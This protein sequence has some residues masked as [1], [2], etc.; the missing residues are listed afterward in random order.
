MVH[1]LA[2]KCRS[3]ERR[4]L[5]TPPAS[6]RATPNNRLTTRPSLLNGARPLRLAAAVALLTDGHKS[7]DFCF[8][9]RLAYG[10]R[11]ST[12]SQAAPAKRKQSNKERILF[13]FCNFFFTSDGLRLRPYIRRRSC[14][15]RRGGVG[16]VVQAAG[17]GIRPS[18][19]RGEGEKE[20]GGLRRSD[21]TMDSKRPFAPPCFVVVVV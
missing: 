9:P 21:S 10:L 13:R 20:E 3:G 18:K 7:Y 15:A 19:Q 5:L 6:Q 14:K 8:H 16:G 12:S 11:R 4:T 2:R 1:I 17:H